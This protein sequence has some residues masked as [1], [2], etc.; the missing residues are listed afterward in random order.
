[1]FIYNLHI[2][3]IITNGQMSLNESR[4]NG[5]GNPL[6]FVVGIVA[7]GRDLL[8]RFWSTETYLERERESTLSFCLV[9]VDVVAGPRE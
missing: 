1:M 5:T 6:C 7:R 8:K 2:S 4:K 9:V 3:L